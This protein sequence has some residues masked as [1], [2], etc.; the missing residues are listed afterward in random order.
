MEGTKSKNVRHEAHV[1]R[2]SD[3]EGTSVCYIWPARDISLSLAYIG[4]P[5]RGEVAVLSY[6][7]HVP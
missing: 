3:I 1:R 6:C 2:R 5:G 7:I 4:T